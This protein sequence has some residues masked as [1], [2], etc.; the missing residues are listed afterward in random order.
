MVI[1]KGAG[2]GGGGSINPQHSLGKP[3]S[4]EKER[5]KC[6]VEIDGWWG[7]VSAVLCVG[8]NC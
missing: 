7:A 8:H 4:G 1:K 6:T 5:S 2:R 3:L